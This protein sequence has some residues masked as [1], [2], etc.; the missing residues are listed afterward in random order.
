M[1]FLVELRG[2]K[3]ACGAN[4]ILAEGSRGMVGLRDLVVPYTP[5]GDVPDDEDA[6]AESLL[7][8]GRNDGHTYFIVHAFIDR[9]SNDKITSHIANNTYGQIILETPINKKHFVPFNRRE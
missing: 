3:S 5:S 9:N 8:T 6:A 7:E 4:A 1:E 2:K